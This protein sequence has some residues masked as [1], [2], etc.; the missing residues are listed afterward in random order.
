[1][2]KRPLKISEMLSNRKSKPQAEEDSFDF[3]AE[4]Q[5]LINRYSTNQKNELDHSNELDEK[6][7]TTTNETS[8]KLVTSDKI[9]TSNQELTI[10]VNPN[11]STNLTFQLQP[12]TEVQIFKVQ[13]DSNS[14]LDNNADIPL[15]AQISQLTG[16]V[17]DPT[18]YIAKS[19]EST[20]NASH[21]QD[22]NPAQTGHKRDT[23]NE[24]KA[25]QTQHKR[26]TNGTQDCQSSS[27]KHD[28]VTKRDTNPAQ[29]GHKR[30]TMTDTK[31]DTNKTQN[32]SVDSCI[33][34]LK[35]NSARLFVYVCDSLILKELTELVC[36]YDQLAYETNIS[37]GSIETTL[38]R[39]CIE[40]QLIIKKTDKGGAGA[41]IY[42]SI[43]QEV[44]LNYTKYQ[45]YLKNNINTGHK[46]DTMTDT[47]RDTNPPSKLVSNNILTNYTGESDHNISTN[48]NAW[49][50]DL[51]F[52]RLPII[53]PMMIN[54]AIRKQVEEKLDRDDVQFF[55]YKFK[56]WLT[57]QQRVQNPVAIFCEKLKEWCIEGDTDVLYALSD[58]E[59][60]AAK[61][62]AE[63]TEKRR[64][65]IELINKAKEFEKSQKLDEEFENWYSN[66]SDEELL[67]LQAPTS[68]LKFKSEIYK[69]TVRGIYAENYKNEEF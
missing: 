23:N 65:Q 26:D 21:K 31:R 12:L 25:T 63:E 30:D 18:Y 67:S 43:E 20:L 41:K 15:N 59:I 49:F 22:T 51:D 28:L 9:S 55:I 32:Y 68:L 60:E 45:T 61:Y 19:V 47:K 6:L 53:R 37:R 62:F 54:A 16:D 58:E 3:L 56:N 42:L 27:I 48:H 69:K 10:K 14:E 4:S 34:S 24:L 64:S 1:M 8:N 50:K 11:H 5:Q 39:L 29:T 52:S 66:A 33:K 40:K 38:K 36:S 35:G 7:V 17:T 57:T 13:A 46:R 44:F 2:A